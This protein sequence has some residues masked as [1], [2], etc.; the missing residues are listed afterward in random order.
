MNARSGSRWLFGLVLA[1]FICGAEASSPTIWFGAEPPIPLGSANPRGG[2]LDYADF[3]ASDQQWQRAAGVISVVEINAA[4]IEKVA[5]PDQLRKAVHV[6]GAHQ[7]KL[8]LELNGLISSLAC[9]G[10][11]F[12]NRDP[13]IPVR[14]LLAAGGTVDY[15]VL[16]EPYAW[17]SRAN[18]P[19]ACHWTPQQVAE[20]L[21]PFL[22]NLRALVPGVKIGDV[23]PLW[24]D[25]DASE[26]ASWTDTYEKATGSKLDFFQMDFDFTRS[27]WVQAGLTVQK[28]MQA[29]GIPFGMHY[30]GNRSDGSDHQWLATAFARSQAFAEA[31]GHPDQIILQSWHPI[32]R[33]ILP[34]SD[35]DSFMGLVLRVAAARGIEKK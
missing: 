9:S 19:G 2:A 27:D 6:L 22:A 11:G 13:L 32:P 24:K 10:N 7:I 30:F 16:N 25:S 17:A 5:K 15:V 26:F 12:A 18:G 14:K 31:G 23:E 21:K 3:L 33:H 20:H 28:A 4:W 35:S 1:L 29:R 8:A 34:E